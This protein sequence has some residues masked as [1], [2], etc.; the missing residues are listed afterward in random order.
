V[1]G[2]TIPRP[3]NRSTP[4]A[5]GFAWSR[6]TTD[7]ADGERLELWRIPRARPRGIAVL[8]PGYAR[9]KDSLLPL[10]AIFRR[11]GY[12]AW[13]VDFRGSGGSSGDVT[14]LGWREAI[15]VQAAVALVSREA[16]GRGLVLYGRSMG[17]VAILRAIGLGFTAPRGVVLEAPY[18]RLL[19]TVGNRFGL[20]GLPAFP[21]AHLLVFWGG[22]QQG[23]NAFSLNPC[24]YAAA[25]RCPALVLRGE[26][27]REVREDDIGRVF[28][29][30]AGP[31]ELAVIPGGAHDEW[32]PASMVFREHVLAGWLA[33][34]EGA[35]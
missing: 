23:F 29:G 24:T 8:F 6:R 5:P 22:A 31:R 32:S 21:L 4:A 18:D 2:I 19:T 27:D 20:M 33:G 12:E 14:S 16:A 3:A 34:V 30:L 17:A 11:L 25:V 7:T 9:S 13:L 10:A 1:T 28:S 26:R 15:D 35:R